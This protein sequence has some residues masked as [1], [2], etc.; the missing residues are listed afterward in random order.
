MKK[1]YRT[2][3]LDRELFDRL[4]KTK[5]GMRMTVGAVAFMLEKSIFAG[6]LNKRLR[7]LGM[8]WE[9]RWL[10]KT[11]APAR[12][13]WE[14]VM[15]FTGSYNDESVIRQLL[16]R[17]GYRPSNLAVQQRIFELIA[18]ERSVSDEYR[19]YALVCLAYLAIRSRSEELAIRTLERIHVVVDD[20]ERDEETYRCCKDNRSNRYKLLI[21]SLVAMAHC[22]IMLEEKSG[23]S[24]VATQGLAAIRKRNWISLPRNVAYRMIS[25][26]ARIAA[27]RAV[28][29]AREDQ[30]DQW[31]LSIDTLVML[32]EEA[33]DERH[34]HSSAQENHLEMVKEILGK[35]KLLYSSANEQL[36][37]FA[38]QLIN[39]PDA[40]MN[41][42]MK[43]L[44]S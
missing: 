11:G 43:A 21:S 28:L 44:L 19:K 32:H 27:W 12:L 9:I 39:P 23:L 8:E 13:I 29:A 34:W 37:E 26:A 4:R 16:F 42:R 24:E 2:K 35:A 20:L 33:C 7:R 10:I 1:Q 41:S 22:Y 38:I 36:S 40:M 31:L 25:N 14:R 5:I 17:R 30:E 15:M 6:V 18:V 3:S